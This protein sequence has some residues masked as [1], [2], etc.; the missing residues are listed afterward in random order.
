[1]ATN[2]WFLE[3]EGKFYGPFSKEKVEE[4][5][6]S[7]KINPA[8]KVSRDREGNQALPL[9]ECPE[10]TSAAPPK[11]VPQ[12]PQTQEKVPTP[13]PEPKP[14]RLMRQEP[15]VVRPSR[16][17]ARK[18]FRWSWLFLALVVG[19]AAV[20]IFWPDPPDSGQGDLIHRLR[21]VFQEATVQ[22]KTIYESAV[23]R[24]LPPFNDLV[25][26]ALRTG[27][28]FRFEEVKR[29]NSDDKII[30]ESIGPRDFGH[31]FTTPIAR[32]IRYVSDGALSYTYLIDRNDLTFAV[33][34]T[35][36]NFD[37]LAL[38]DYSIEAFSETA[39]PPR[40]TPSEVIWE[41]KLAGTTLARA[42]WSK[43]RERR[44]LAYI[45]VTNEDVVER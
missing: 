12:A 7:G 15:V 14:P 37:K 22:R 10:F 16:P 20:L 17:K 36:P 8:T 43:Q 32:E 4:L 5:A 28:N 24:D 42:V 39:L 40:E 34:I 35:G 33:I 30:Y 3:R 23:V 6:R 44:P 29:L 21:S 1:M 19:G 27:L 38:S 41:T 45:L 25:Q 31:L 9:G 13:N 26:K 2:G 11:P 18:G